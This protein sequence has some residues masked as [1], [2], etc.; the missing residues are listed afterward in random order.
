M[1]S[2]FQ[3]A[4]KFSSQS[5]QQTMLLSFSRPTSLLGNFSD[6]EQETRSLIPPTLK[7]EIS[8]HY[9]KSYPM[10]KAEISGTF[11]ELSIR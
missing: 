4:L 3:A 5:P 8:E 6:K 7:T 1:G 9:V 11:C 2:P 10:V